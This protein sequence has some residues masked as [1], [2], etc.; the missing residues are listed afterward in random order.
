M[1]DTPQEESVVSQ[2][3]Y[4]TEETTQAFATLLN[5]EETARNEEL[6]APKSKEGEV[7]LAKDNDDPLQQ[8]I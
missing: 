6:D 1:A 5:K 3:T 8:K 2:P 7:D 4:N